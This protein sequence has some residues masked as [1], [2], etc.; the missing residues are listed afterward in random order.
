MVRKENKKL[1]WLT[2]MHMPAKT[3]GGFA[4]HLIDGREAIE[5]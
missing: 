5:T 3:A 4:G 1:V 2:R